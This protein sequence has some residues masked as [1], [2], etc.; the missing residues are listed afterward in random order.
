MSSDGIMTCSCFS[1]STRRGATSGGVPGTSA[2]ALMRDMCVH[3]AVMRRNEMVTISR[4]IIGIMLISESSDLREA[5]CSADVHTGHVR[6]PQLLGRAG[7]GIPWVSR[8]ARR[9]AAAAV[10]SFG[11][12][13]SIDARRARARSVRPAAA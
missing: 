6:P 1:G 7:A 13:R 8:P 12:S 9:P 5:R 11:L 3:T 2:F 4:S 10:A